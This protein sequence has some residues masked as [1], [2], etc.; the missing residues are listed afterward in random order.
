LIVDT[1]CSDESFFKLLLWRDTNFAILN[2]EDSLLAV[3]GR[4]ILRDS[5]VNAIQSTRLHDAPALGLPLL[6]PIPK[7]TTWYINATSTLDAFAPFSFGH[8]FL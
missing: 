5:A 1:A 2:D 8:L 3:N 4:A 6:A 7:P